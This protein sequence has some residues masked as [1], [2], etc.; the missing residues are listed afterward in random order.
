MG[1]CLS[2]RGTIKLVDNLGAEAEAAMNTMD[3][4]SNYIRTLSESKLKEWMLGHF[5]S[6][7]LQSKL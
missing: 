4:V 3:D 1:F 7:V 6:V 5:A 2:H